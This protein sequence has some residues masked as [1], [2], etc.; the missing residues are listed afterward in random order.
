MLKR[1]ADLCRER[2]VSVFEVISSKVPVLISKLGFP[3]VGW[4]KMSVARNR[5]VRFLDCPSSRWSSG[6][7]HSCPSFRGH[8][9]AANLAFPPVGEGIPAAEQWRLF[10]KRFRMKASLGSS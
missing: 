9:L 8:R 3:G 1:E 2:P 5:N 10:I 6:G 4:L 7:S